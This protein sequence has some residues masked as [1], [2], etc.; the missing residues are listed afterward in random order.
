MRSAGIG[1]TWYIQPVSSVCIPMVIKC[2][3]CDV[4]IRELRSSV[5]K[6]HKNVA[7]LYKERLDAVVRI[8]R[9]SRSLFTDVFACNMIVKNINFIKNKRFTNILE[10]SAYIINDDEFESGLNGLFDYIYSNASNHITHNQLMRF[11]SFWA[12]PVFKDRHEILHSWIECKDIRKACDVNVSVYETEVPIQIGTALYSSD[13]RGEVCSVDTSRFS[14]RGVVYA[15][16]DEEM[17]PFQSSRYVN[18]GEFEILLAT[19]RLITDPDIMCKRYGADVVYDEDSMP[20]LSTGVRDIMY[21]A[22]R[23]VRMMHDDD[24]IVYDGRAEAADRVD[25]IIHGREAYNKDVIVFYGKGCGDVSYDATDCV[26][27]IDTVNECAKSI[28]VEIQVLVARAIGKADA[29]RYVRW[30][31]D[32]DPGARPKRLVRFEHSDGP[33]NG[34]AYID[35]IDM[36]GDAF[37]NHYTGGD[38]VVN[39]VI[40]EHVDGCFFYV[41]NGDGSIII[42]YAFSSNDLVRVKSVLGMEEYDGLCVIEYFYD[43]ENAKV[44]ALLRCGDGKD[45]GERMLVLDG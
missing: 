42:G 15:H 43:Y 31:R 8:V 18:A 38:P 5:G 26:G 9:A 12:S 24:M 14:R 28:G 41:F 1:M 44:I 35:Y 22:S 23:I 6:I 27:D 30:R 25:P 19:V 11:M 4:L 20:E 45:S 37:T 29:V 36:N 16:T 40:K 3:E 21:I 34:D 2:T 13:P 7:Y 17:K 39:F 33:V 10:L 32:D